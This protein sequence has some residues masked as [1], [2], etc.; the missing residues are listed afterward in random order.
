MQERR[1]TG[2]GQEFPR[3][4]FTLHPLRDQDGA[5]RAMIVLP[6]V[7]ERGREAGGRKVLWRVACFASAG[8][9]WCCVATC[10][11][12]P[13]L[14]GETFACGCSSPHVACMYLAVR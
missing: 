5:L 13:T 8:V 6:G 3:V 11:I 4:T 9:P 7:A 2:G 10:L 14:C 1:G 12:R